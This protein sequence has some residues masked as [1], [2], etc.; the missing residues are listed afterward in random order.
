[1]RVG[2][3]GRR[4]RRGWAGGGGATG[5]DA[6]DWRAAAGRYQAQL[7]RLFVDFFFLFSPSSHTDV[8]YTAEPE[9][10]NLKFRFFLRISQ[11]EHPNSSKRRLELNQEQDRID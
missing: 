2:A 9:K 8:L 11:L 5:A 4:R 3:G 10:N 7:T 6:G 1:M